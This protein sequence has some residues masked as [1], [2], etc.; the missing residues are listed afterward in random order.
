[1]QDL[2]IILHITLKI[3]LLKK[4]FKKVKKMFQKENDSKYKIKIHNLNIH[5]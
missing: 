2:K 4:I 1:M 3:H 5:L